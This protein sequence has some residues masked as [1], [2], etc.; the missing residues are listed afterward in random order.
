MFNSDMDK[1]PTKLPQSKMKAGMIEMTLPCP[2]RHTIFYPGILA[3]EALKEKKYYVFLTYCDCQLGHI[4]AT[5][6]N[7]THARMAGDPVTIEKWYEKIPWKERKIFD[8]KGVFY[9]KEA[10]SLPA[11]KYYFEQNKS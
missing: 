5:Q 3:A 9:C 1:F 4:L 6:D 7:G 2:N 11:L 10:P 8:S